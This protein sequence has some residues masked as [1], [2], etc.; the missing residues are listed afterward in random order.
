MLWNNSAITRE[1]EMNYTHCYYNC[2]KVNFKQLEKVIIRL[3]L[4]IIIMKS[5]MMMQELDY[6]N[7]KRK[8]N[9]LTIVEGNPKV[10]VSLVATLM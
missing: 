2:N 3:L 1:I 5:I 6:K 8:G 4:I 7:K 10:P 9:W